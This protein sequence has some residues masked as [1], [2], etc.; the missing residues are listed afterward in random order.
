[1]QTVDTVRV[2]PPESATLTVTS[3]LLF[4]D[5]TANITVSLGK[6]AIAHTGVTVVLAYLGTKASISFPAEVVF[7]AGTNVVIVTLTALAP[8]PLSGFSVT[9]TRGGDVFI[10]SDATPKLE[11]R[12]RDAAQLYYSPSTT[13]LVVG[14]SFAPSFGIAALP[15]GGALVVTFTYGSE[16]TIVTANGDSALT[17]TAQSSTVQLLTLTGVSPTAAKSLHITLSGDAAPQYLLA[18]NDFPLPVYAKKTVL[19]QTVPAAM[20][21]GSSN[22][23]QLIVELNETSSVPLQ[24]VT[25]V[26]TNTEAVEFFPSTVTLES[27]KGK[28]SANV[29]VSGKSLSGFTVAASVLSAWGE[30]KADAVVVGSSWTVVKPLLAC[31]VINYTGTVYIGSEM[32]FVVQ[33]PQS[34]STPISVSVVIGNHTAIISPNPILFSPGGSTV[35]SV[36]IS[37]TTSQWSTPF[38]LTTAGSSI[39]EETCFSAEALTSAKQDSITVER[40]TSSFDGVFVG[41]ANAVTCYMTIRALPDTSIVTLELP[42][43]PV[44]PIRPCDH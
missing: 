12:N 25:V 18:A 28:G 21:I 34:P 39:F 23:Q 43:E 35:A 20:Y 15:A 8:S 14:E 11:V 26:F 36:T 5:G 16:V 41:E 7:P 27:A 6:P 44:C 29:T 1:M 17:F 24:K 4:V 22:G 40:C 37:N 38:K 13:F 30:Y 3:P 42:P 19:I 9:V 10:P 31:T 32:T 33:L 2:L